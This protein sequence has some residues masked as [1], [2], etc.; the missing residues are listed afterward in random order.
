[1]GHLIA[2]EL[3]VQEEAMAMGLVQQELLVKVHKAVHRRL[4][5]VVALQ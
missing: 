1:V 3:E 4:D 2:L 5:L